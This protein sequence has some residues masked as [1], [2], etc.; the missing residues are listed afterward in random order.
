LLIFSY[1]DNTIYRSLNDF[2]RWNKDVLDNLT[3]HNIEVS[4]KLA[5]KLEQALEKMPNMEWEL[6]YRWDDWEWW[7]WNVWDKIDLKAF[8]SVSDNKKD[9]FISEEKNILVIIGWKEW[10]VKNI[11]QLA[12]IPNFWEYFPRIPKT[13]NE[14]VVLPN[15]KVIIIGNDKWL[16]KWID[17]TEIRVKQTK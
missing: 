13:T 4:K 11:T 8:T 1:T 17:I 3:P 16:H 15:S 6:V 14:W 7:K 5:W 10:R 2:L 12:L 9:T